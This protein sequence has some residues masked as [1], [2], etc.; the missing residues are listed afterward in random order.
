MENLQTIYKAPEVQEQAWQDLAQGFCV[1]EVGESF[2][3]SL[4][5]YLAKSLKAEYVIIG[6]LL[7]PGENCLRTMAVYISGKV[8]SNT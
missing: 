6:K 1:P 3:I 4:S 2:F 5:N 7:K 8:V